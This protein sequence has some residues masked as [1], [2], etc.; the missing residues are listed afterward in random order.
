MAD[1]YKLN[2]DFEYIHT[3]TYLRRGDIIEYMRDLDSYVKI[4]PYGMIQIPASV[5]KKHTEVFEL[6]PPH[7]EN[8]YTQPSML[9]NYA[10][11]DSRIES[12]IR[13]YAHSAGEEKLVQ[14]GNYFMGKTKTRDVGMAARIIK[15]ILL[16]IKT[17]FI[18]TMKKGDAYYAIP[19]FQ[20]S[21]QPILYTYDKNLQDYMYRLLGN[22][23]PADSD[24]EAQARDWAEQNQPALYYFLNSKF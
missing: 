23:F 12:N 7:E 8:E 13:S 21:A 16:A 14:N 2:Q 17:P 11:I 1:R 22:C 19:L 3:M 20:E 5:V 4:K 10:Y 15:M 9:D 18:H 6:L 24:G